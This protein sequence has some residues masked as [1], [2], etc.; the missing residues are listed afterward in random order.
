M[1]KSTGAAGVLRAI[2]LSV[3]VS[4]LERSLRFYREG[5]GFRELMRLEQGQEV[6][7]I[8]QFEGE[9]RFIS[10]LVMRDGMVLQIITW[11]AP[12][13]IAAKGTK[14]LNECGLTHIGIAVEDV[15]HAIA[16]LVA[17]GGSVIEATRTRLEG[18]DVVMMLDPDGTRIEIERVDNLPDFAAAS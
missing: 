11:P 12:G 14:R 5:L 2:H 18:A 4:D 7:P 3:V 16:A 13:T 10:A 17:L 9:V 1:S 8:G 6:A 15:D